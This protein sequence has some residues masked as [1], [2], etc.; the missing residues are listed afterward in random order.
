[1]DNSAIYSEDHKRVN[2]KF[3]GVV[4]LYMFLGLVITALAAFG[5]AA[6]LANV[7]PDANQPS[8]LNEV[9]QEILIFSAI[10]AG[11]ISIADSFLMPVLARKSGRAPWFGFILY[12]LCMG[13]ML[14]AILLLG[15][16]FEIIG[17]AFGI[18]A[19]IFL[20]MAGIGALSKV[21]LTPLA[22]IGICLLVGIFFI[23]AFWG[24]Y[25]LIH[26]YET[27]LLYYYLISMGVIVV[28]MLFIAYDVNRMVAIADQGMATTNTAL[29]CAFS[30]YGDF[31]VLFIRILYLLLATRRN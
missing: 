13:I 18:T 14:S 22:Y 23:S 29:Y 26:G 21:N 2:V 5:F 10:G 20:V 11:I 16:P 25:M 3:L 28:M 4:F 24:I 30:L 6:F 7:Y 17:E 15:V 1:M 8:R 27:Y 9:G 19:L 12:A 31:L